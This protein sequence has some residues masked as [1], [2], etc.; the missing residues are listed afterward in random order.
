MAKKRAN[1]RKENE[2]SNEEK[3]K[4]G[5]WAIILLFASI[6]NIA[7]Y[8]EI[9]LY[10]EFYMIIPLILVILMQFLSLIEIYLIAKGK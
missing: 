10:K 5:I 4:I 3:L 7:F 6:G 1:K 2:L 9:T 8:Y